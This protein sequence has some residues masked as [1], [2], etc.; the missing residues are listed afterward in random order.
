MIFE[1]ALKK[2]KY[3]VLHKLATGRSRTERSF[4][5]GDIRWEKST[6]LHVTVALIIF[7][8]IVFE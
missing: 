8:I 5:R 2:D 1:K 4:I 7:I 3:D 6:K